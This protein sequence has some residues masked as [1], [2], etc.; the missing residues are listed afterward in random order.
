MEL[1][2]AKPQEEEEEEEERPKRSVLFNLTVM[3]GTKALTEKPC[4]LSDDDRRPND[5]IGST[6]ECDVTTEK[7]ANKSQ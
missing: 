2:Q 7:S 5:L 1:T 4:E 3:V 6:A